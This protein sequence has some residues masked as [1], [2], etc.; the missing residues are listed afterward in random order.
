MQK[1]LEISGR[2]CGRI[3][4]FFAALRGIGLEKKDEKADK[5][6]KDETA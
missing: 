4:A 3:W 6:Y 1:I 2:K 5:D